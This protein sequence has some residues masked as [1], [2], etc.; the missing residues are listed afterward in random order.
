MRG[1]SLG[2]IV[3]GHLSQGSKRLFKP[4]LFYLVP[5]ILYLGFDVFFL[6]L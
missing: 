6:D 4:L 3:T 2:D 1:P 5:G